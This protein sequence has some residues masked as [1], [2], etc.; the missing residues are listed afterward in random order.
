[1]E[2][3]HKK[4]FTFIIVAAVVIGLLT[5]AFSDANSSS[6]NLGGKLP[7]K[8]EEDTDAEEEEEE[9]FTYNPP[10]TDYDE[11]DDEEDSTSYDSTPSENKRKHGA[12][13]P[14]TDEYTSPEDFYYNFRD[15][16]MD[17]DEAEEYYYEHGGE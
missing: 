15:D 4:I 6:A 5:A 7:S 3:K 2:D 8:T 16:F 12:Y 11:D 13:Y 9:T 14:E 1:M 17:Y 10:V